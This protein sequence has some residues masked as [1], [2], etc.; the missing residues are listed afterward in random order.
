MSRNIGIN[1]NYDAIFF[2]S[3]TKTKLINY[4]L[5]YNYY[6]FI[7][8]D[9]CLFEVLFMLWQIFLVDRVEVTRFTFP[10]VS[11]VSFQHKLNSQTE[12]F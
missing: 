8:L 1:R 10:H 6:I 3:G 9:H 4:D 11:T 7:P 5:I 2:C 12:F